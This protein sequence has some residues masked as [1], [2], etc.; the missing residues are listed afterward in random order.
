M[1][2]GAI[3]TWAAE[4]VVEIGKFDV[5]VMRTSP[6]LVEIGFYFNIL[7]VKWWREVL[8]PDLSGISLSMESGK[9]PVKMYFSFSG[10][11]LKI[12]GASLKFLESTGLGICAMKSGNKNV[13]SSLKFPSSNMSKN[14]QPPGPRS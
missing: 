4:T 2:P 12:S 13:E 11:V 5:S 9:E 14:S 6:A 7:W 3:V 10:I 1:P 8:I